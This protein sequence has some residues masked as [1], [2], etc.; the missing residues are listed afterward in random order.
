M[1]HNGDSAEWRQTFGLRRWGAQRGNLRL[2]GKRIVLRGAAVGRVAPQDLLLAQQHDA[3]LLLSH[4][5]DDLCD[6]ASGL[7]VPL[8]LDLRRNQSDLATTLRRL[9]WQP[10]AL[11][12][13]ID[14]ALPPYFIPTNSV[15]IARAISADAA[16]PFPGGGIS[17][18]A[19][20][21]ELRTGERPPDWVAWSPM[22]VIVVRRGS[23]CADLREARAA[24]DRLQAELAPEFNLAGYFVSS[25]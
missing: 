12:L 24:C 3:A 10:A 2:D 8:I 20:V 1:R 11:V 6:E 23:P 17:A 19:L 9:A 4:P 16:D 25:D 7:G 14:E 5:S 22:P 15:F 13:L 21:I 18:H